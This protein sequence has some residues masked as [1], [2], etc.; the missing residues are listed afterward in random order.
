[1]KDCL[2]YIYND[3]GYAQ[4]PFLWNRMGV[5]AAFQLQRL[6]W[7]STANRSRERKIRGCL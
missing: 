1:M 3:G 2:N 4:I 5:L 7:N 6:K